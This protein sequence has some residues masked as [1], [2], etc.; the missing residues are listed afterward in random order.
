MY[1]PEVLY[2][3]LRVK[4]ASGMNSD[5]AFFSLAEELHIPPSDLSYALRSDAWY[6]RQRARQIAKAMIEKEK[7]KK[8]EE[9]Q[10][11]R[12]KAHYE[13]VMRQIHREIKRDMERP[14][15]PW[16]LED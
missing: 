10:E 8:R 4:R 2:E 16:L 5:Q 6:A 3:M 11:V 1:T 14:I 7:A 13:K 15:K 9:R 12:M